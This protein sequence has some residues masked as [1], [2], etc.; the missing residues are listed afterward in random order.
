MSKSYGNTIPFGA[1]PEEV[2]SRINM[3]ITDPERIKK[4]DK[5]HPDI[6]IVYAFQ[7]VFNEEESAS[8]KAQCEAGEIGC[9]KCKKCLGEKMNT[10]LA[11]IH[12]KRRELEKRPDYIKD[13]LDA[14]AKK[15]QEVA[16]AN[17]SEIK[18]AMNIY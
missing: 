4:T 7:K 14:G 18:K 17:M 5:G 2:Q 11:D 10:L 13:I 6:C 1:P 15:A 9:V 8:I 3:M 16:A 12:A